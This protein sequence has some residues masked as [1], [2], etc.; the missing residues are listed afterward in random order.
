MVTSIIDGLILGTAY[1]AEVHNPAVVEGDY[2]LEQEV[3]VV[4][5]CVFVQMHVID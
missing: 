5:G 4:A 2:C 3:H 1:W